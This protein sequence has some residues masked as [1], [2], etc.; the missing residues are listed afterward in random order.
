VK[1]DKVIAH[2]WHHTF[3]WLRRKELDNAYEGFVYEDGDG[4]LIISK[5]LRHIVE[6]YLDCW[7]DANTGEKYLCFSKLPRTRRRKHASH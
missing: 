4:D 5:D 7:E 1:E 6:A 2:G 3:G